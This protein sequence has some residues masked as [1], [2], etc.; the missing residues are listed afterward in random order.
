MEEML[1]AATE[2]V[3]SCEFSEEERYVSSRGTFRAD[4]EHLTVVIG[5]FSDYTSKAIDEIP[6]TT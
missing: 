6:T 5:L 4:L 2:E 3:N 1:L